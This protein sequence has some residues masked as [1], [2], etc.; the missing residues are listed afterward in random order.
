MAYQP[1]PIDTAQVRLT[2]ELEQLVE[3]LSENVHDHWA[4]RRMSEGWVH[5][6]QR[7]DASKTHPDLVPYAVAVGGGK[8]VRPHDGHRNG[9]GHPR[10][11]L[12]D[13]RPVR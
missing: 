2:P 13:P 11:G 7:N 6:P 9:E 12:R 1:R 5:G 10:A 4:A 3:R 8:A